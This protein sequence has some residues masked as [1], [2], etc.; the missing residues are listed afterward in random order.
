M[1]LAYNR[2][3]TGFAGKGV[4]M[5][6][7]RNV[8]TCCVTGRRKIPADRIEYVNRELY[9]EVLQAVKDG[10][11]HFISGFSE[12]TDLLFSAAVATFIACLQKT[13]KRTFRLKERL[14]L[15]VE[16]D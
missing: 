16:M 6:E 14:M 10:F 3:E 11:T 5:V 8:K 4:V 15:S 7:S 2:Y 12:G 13:G 1:L 9:R